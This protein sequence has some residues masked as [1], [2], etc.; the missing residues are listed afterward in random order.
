M[1]LRTSRTPVSRLTA[2]LFVSLLAL[3]LGACSDSDGNARGENRS[4]STLNDLVVADCNDLPEDTKPLAIDG[5]AFTN[6]TPEDTV[7]ENSVEGQ[8]CI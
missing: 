5:L 6:S 2:M 4:F 8:A 7:P 3:G 1:K